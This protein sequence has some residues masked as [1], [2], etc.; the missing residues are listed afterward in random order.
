MIGFYAYLV[1]LI[2][3]LLA[4]HV[5]AL[6]SL[7][8]SPCYPTC[9]GSNTTIASDLVC[10]DNDFTNTPNGIVLADCVSCLAN[11]SYSQGPVSDTMLFLGMIS[12]SGRITKRV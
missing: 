11:S 10:T 8:G 9:Q 12:A 3:S 7:S 1:P 2:V 6:S 5:K 4:G